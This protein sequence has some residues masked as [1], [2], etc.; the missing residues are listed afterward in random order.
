MILTNGII[1]LPPVRESLTKP[2]SLGLGVVSLLFVVGLWLMR[3]EVAQSFQEMTREVRKSGASWFGFWV[4]LSHYVGAPLLGAIIGALGL[5]SLIAGIRRLV[6]QAPLDDLPEAPWM[7][8]PIVLFSCAVGVLMWGLHLRPS[9]VRQ[10]PATI[11]RKLRRVFIE[12]VVAIQANRFFVLLLDTVSGD[13]DWV[14]T[15]LVLLLLGALFYL[16]LQLL[17]WRLGDRPVSRWEV[18]K[19]FLLLVAVSLLMQITPDGWLGWIA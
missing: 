11:R 17:I 16:P 3:Y 5:S 10:R 13:K 9:A 12:L 6:G 8:L 1:L 18:R 7:I 19:L 15:T 4:Q 2:H 14:M